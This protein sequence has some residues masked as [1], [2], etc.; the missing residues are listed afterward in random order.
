MKLEIVLLKQ[1]PG[2]LGI[3]I[4]GKPGDPDGQVQK[5]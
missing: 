4:L 2:G 5:H 3:Q 1:L